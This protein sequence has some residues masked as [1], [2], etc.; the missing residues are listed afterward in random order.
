M[1]QPNYCTYLIL[2]RKRHRYATHN[3]SF[4]DVSTTK[5]GVKNVAEIF[6][7]T[8]LIRYISWL[9]KRYF[10]CRF[11]LLISLYAGIFKLFCVVY[12]S[13]IAMHAYMLCYISTLVNLLCQLMIRMKYGHWLV[14]L[15]GILIRIE[16]K[17]LRQ[18]WYICSTWLLA[19]QNFLVFSSFYLF[20]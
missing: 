6:L 16:L 15:S 12:V 8:E 14:S 17:M 1:H 11:C 13:Y 10:E 3:F 4:G 9:I 18:I 20:L 5:H 2:N 7:G 19:L